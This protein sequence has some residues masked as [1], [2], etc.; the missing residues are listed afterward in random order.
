[1]AAAAAAAAATATTASATRMA[2]PRPF[3]RMGVC[4]S[5]STPAGRRQRVHGVVHH[6]ERR[7]FED[8]R[9][10][11][12]HDLHHQP[13]AARPLVPALI[14]P[15]VRRLAHARRE[16]QRAFE[17]ADDFAEVHARGVARQLVPAAKPALAPDDAAALEFEQ[18]SLEELLG[19]P[20][21]LG[22]VRSQDGAAAGTPWRGPGALS[23]RTSTSSSARE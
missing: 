10:L 15:V 17:N 8:P 23:G 1:M 19:D 18:D 6:R 20:L 16:R 11:V 13:D 5:L 7:A 2:A 22:Q 3:Q 21:A 12:A 14:A 9:R 4:L